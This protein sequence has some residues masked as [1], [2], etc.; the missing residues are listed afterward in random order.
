M[1]GRQ[2]ATRPLPA[3]DGEEVAGWD[4]GGDPDGVEDP[5]PAAGTDRLE[6]GA[7][8]EDAA[9]AGAEDADKAPGIPTDAQMTAYGPP[10]PSQTQPAF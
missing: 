7:A 3:G 4:D 6:V 8:D 10:K 1:L 5:T 2:W 9:E